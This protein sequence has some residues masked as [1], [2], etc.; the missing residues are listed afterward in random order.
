MAEHSRDQ[1]VE[2]AILK[3]AEI[4]KKV[5]EN[6][7]DAAFNRALDALLASPAKDASASSLG[8]GRALRSG[9]DA[10]DPSSSQNPNRVEMM[11]SNFDTTA[12]PE[13]GAHKPPLENALRILQAAREALQIDGLTPTEVAAILRDKFRVSVAESSVRMALGRAGNLVNRVRRGRAFDYRIMAPGD[14]YLAS[15][16]RTQAVRAAGTGKR[17]PR[18]GRAAGPPKSRGE[19]KARS[20]GIKGG[21]P[22]QALSGRP[23]PT[24]VVNKLVADGFFKE[25]K[26]VAEVLEHVKH[27]RGY[28][29]KTSDI[30][31][32]LLRLVRGEKIERHRNKDRQYEY[33][34]R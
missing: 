29:F 28:T 19:L 7:Q 27:K 23:G 2:E 22:K 5:P 15:P 12:F 25:A 30:A 32:S 21:G 11:M 17:R 9:S 24:E 3:A 10:A 4:A 6:L 34:A 1:S 20:E 13:I 33:K 8:G 31:V 16:A 26:T 18:A 14:T